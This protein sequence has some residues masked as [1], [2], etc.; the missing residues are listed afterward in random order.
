MA[1]LRSILLVKVLEPEDDADDDAQPTPVALN[2]VSLGTI[3]EVKGLLA[4][5]NTMP[6]GDPTTRHVL[7]GPGITVSLPMG[8]RDDPVNQALVGVSEDDIAW[9]TLIR[10]CRSLGWKMMDPKSGRTFG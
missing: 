10:I 2:M 5:F 7:Y 3:D 9:A 1:G 4:Q 8:D 6:D